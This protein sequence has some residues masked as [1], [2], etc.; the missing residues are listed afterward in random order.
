V[1]VVEGGC[2]CGALRYAVDLSLAGEGQPLRTSLCHCRDCRRCAGAP[3][4]S[5]TAVPSASFELIA[6]EPAVYRSS[7]DAQRSFCP[8]CG[9]GLFYVNETAL[10][11]I[12]D[13][14]TAS[15]DDPEAFPAMAQVQ[16]A[17]R[18]AWMEAAHELPQFER[19]PGAS[20]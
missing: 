12:V 16:T 13:I 9:T 20:A 11:G 1:I 5:W 19:F 7:E 6:G 2:H 15:L 17:E 8:H 18:I 14:Q 10:P 3:M 4:V